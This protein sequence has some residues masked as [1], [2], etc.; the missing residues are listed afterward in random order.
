MLLAHR[1]LK[2]AQHCLSL[3]SFEAAAHPQF[4]VAHCTAAHRSS[5]FGPN[6]VLN[7]VAACI[8]PTELNVAGTKTRRRDWRLCKASCFRW[9]PAASRSWRL[10][11]PRWPTH[12]CSTPLSCVRTRLSKQHTR[13]HRS[14][15]SRYAPAV[16]CLPWHPI[17]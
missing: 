8:S 14:R 7:R 4:D 12:A 3:I 16:P 17:A 10:R 15:P 11:G 13:P 6:R 1:S 9:I 2:H 5:R